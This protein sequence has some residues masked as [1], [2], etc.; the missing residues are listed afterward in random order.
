MILFYGEGRLGNQLFQYQALSRIA[1]D[2]ERIVAVGLEDLKR[3]F[4]LLGPHVVALTRFGLNMKRVVKYLLIPLLL[5]PLA[6][7]LRLLNYAYEAQGGPPEHHGHSGNLQ[8]RRG[9]LRHLTFVDGGYYHNAS[10]WTSIFPLGCSTVNTDLRQA[11][12]KYLD[13]VCGVGVRPT[14]IHVRRRDYLGYTAYGVGDVALPVEFYRR[15]LLEIE[16]LIGKR[17]LVFVTDDPQW[18]HEQFQDIPDKLIPTFDAALDF[19]IMTQSGSGVLSNST[20]SLAAALMMEQPE[21]I[22][23]PQFWFG[24]RVGQWLPPRIKIEH[25]KLL[26]LPVSPAQQAP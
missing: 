17:P 5:R 23:A 25:E 26:Y 19:A 11:A 1:R 3:H 10:L 20:F 13:A 9:I 6:R 2:Q 12:R 7:T 4:D 18:V 15:A 21:V 24:F 22:V 8:H 16:R 14:F